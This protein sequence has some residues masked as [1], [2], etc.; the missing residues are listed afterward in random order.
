MTHE[1]CFYFVAIACIAAL[2]FDFRGYLRPVAVCVGMSLTY[3]L[4]E[5]LFYSSSA[6][7][8]ELSLPSLVG[9]HGG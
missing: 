7:A 6:W 9:G 3:V 1:Y 4:L 8:G 2:I 5:S